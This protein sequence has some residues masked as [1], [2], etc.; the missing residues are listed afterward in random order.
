MAIQRRLCIPYLFYLQNKI[1]WFSLYSTVNLT[2]SRV[3][4]RMFNR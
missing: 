2:G 4:E 1:H 3:I